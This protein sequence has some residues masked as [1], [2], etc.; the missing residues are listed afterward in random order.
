MA[1]GRKTGGKDWEPGFSRNPAGRPPDPIH[2]RLVKKVSHSDFKYAL[3][4]ILQARPEE[5]GTF[6]G[7]ILEMALASIMQQAI[8]YGDHNKLEFLINRLYGKV[9]D[10]VEVTEMDDLKT[11]SDEALYERMVESLNEMK[12]KLI[13]EKK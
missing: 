10:K 1:K 12:Q 4:S 2:V 11:L 3:Q 13:G 8:K 7:N 6:K 9:P 5:L